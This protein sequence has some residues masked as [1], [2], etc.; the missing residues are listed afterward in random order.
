MRSWVLYIYNFDYLYG[1]GFEL[2]IYVLEP[3][4]MI[5]FTFSNSCW[6]SSIGFR[7]VEV[8][9]IL[10]MVRIQGYDSKSVN[11]IQIDMDCII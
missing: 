4:G 5:Q 2:N 7:V 9:A 8:D 6:L 3:L 11:L 10:D 1:W